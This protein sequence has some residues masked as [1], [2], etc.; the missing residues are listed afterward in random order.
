MQNDGT[1]QMVLYERLWRYTLKQDEI[2]K[3]DAKSI[4]IHQNITH[5]RL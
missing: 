4:K 2:L 3:D 5:E 1:T